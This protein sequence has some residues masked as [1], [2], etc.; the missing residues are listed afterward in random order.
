LIDLTLPD[1]PST[2]IFVHDVISFVFPIPRHPKELY[3][4]TYNSCVSVIILIF[5]P[6]L[7][8][9]VA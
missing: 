4:V 6:L 3:P 7:P 9:R 8:L 2:L 5:G 1:S